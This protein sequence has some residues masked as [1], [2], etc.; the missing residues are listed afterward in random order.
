MTT[1]FDRLSEINQFELRKIRNAI[2]TASE[3]YEAAKLRIENCNANHKEK[4]RELRKQIMKMM[5]RSPTKVKILNQ[6]RIRAM[7]EELM[8]LE[9]EGLVVAEQLE[10]SNRVC[11]NLRQANR[12]LRRQVKCLQF[13]MGYS[14]ESVRSI[15]SHF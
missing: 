14:T 7:K 12:D 11:S 15:A 2:R 4:M 1:Q 9:R 6:R 5:N 8:N 10:E 3:K 13:K